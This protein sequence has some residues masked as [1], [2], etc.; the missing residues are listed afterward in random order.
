MPQS[1]QEFLASYDSSAFE[2]MSLAADMLI[3]SV[4][5]EEADNYRKAGRK[6]FSI[7]LVQ[8]SEYPFKGKWSLPG[9][10][11]NPK[12]TIEA[13]ASRVLERE[14]NLSG[15]YMEQLYTFSA[16]RRDPRMRIVSCAYLALVDKS[17]FMDGMDASAHWFNIEFSETVEGLAVSLASGD[18]KICFSVQGKEFNEEALKISGGELLGFDHAKMIAM[19]ILRLKNKIEYMDLVFHMLPEYFTLGELQQ[20]YEVI[21]GRKLL[22][23]AFR[24]IIADKVEKTGK[25]QTGGGHRPSALFRYKGNW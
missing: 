7:L 20:V 10:F 14:T 21:L 25:V 19:G 8:R 3:F 24:R 2:K 23:P 5:S 15:L 22:A 12:E 13:A 1:E 4:S 11:V 16:L 9:G 17:K 6:H 18:D